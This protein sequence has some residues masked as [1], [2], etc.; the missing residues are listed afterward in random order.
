MNDRKD[1]TAEVIS[2]KMAAPLLHAIDALA[3]RQFR[4]RSDIVRQS[5]LRELEQNG[6]CPAR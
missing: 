2:V 6:L 4:S 1:N 5:V 3:E